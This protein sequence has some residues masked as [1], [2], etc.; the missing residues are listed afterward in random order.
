VS[1][2]QYAESKRVERLRQHLRDAD[3]VTSALY[4]AGWGSSAAFYASAP[5]HLGMRP[6]AYRSGAGGDSIRFTIVD[7]PIGRLLM[8][9]TERGVCSIRIGEDD[10]TLAEQLHGEFPRAARIVRD[11]AGLREWVD[12][13]RR[14][15]EGSEPHLDLPLDIRATSFQR[16]VWEALRAIPYGETRTYGEIAATVGSPR[17]ARAVGQAC[18]AN[19]VSIVVPCHR[20]VAGGG[21]L[22]GYGWGLDRKRWLLDHEALRSTEHRS[23]VEA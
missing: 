7:S 16:R 1:P 13:V 14:N 2:R 3:S 5:A 23:P 22:G 11:D 6:A 15:L 21:K 12:A 17:A 10:G 20:V 9:A 18:G 8:A 4:D 19:P